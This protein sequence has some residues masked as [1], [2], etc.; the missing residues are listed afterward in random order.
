MIENHR[1]GLI[2]IGELKSSSPLLDE[3]ER[4]QWVG[5]TQNALRMKINQPLWPLHH[6]TQTNILD[7][8]CIA[9]KGGRK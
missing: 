8:F 4:S 5:P 2:W 6:L 3:I 1:L 7:S 9:T